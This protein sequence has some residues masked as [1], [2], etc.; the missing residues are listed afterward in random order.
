MD[1]RRLFAKYRESKLASPI[2]SSPPLLDVELVERQR[3]GPDAAPVLRGL[4]LAPGPRNRTATQ[5]G[6]VEVL[7]GREG[8]FLTAR[9]Q[10]GLTTLLAKRDDGSPAR[11][12]V[13]IK[14]AHPG[15]E[16]SDVVAMLLFADRTLADFGRIPI[17][18]AASAPEL[19]E[20]LCAS[21]LAAAQS[22]YRRGASKTY[23]HQSVV[24]RTVKG[25]LDMKD[26]ALRRLRGDPRVRSARHLHTAE[27][28]YNWVVA[29]GL[30][31]ASL[32]ASDPSLRM[33]CRAA[34]RLYSERRPPFPRLDRRLKFVGQYAHYRHL[35]ALAALLAAG[36][37]SDPAAPGA[38]SFLP[39]SITPHVLF[40]RF[41]ARYLEQELAGLCTVRRGIRRHVFE[42]QDG[43]LL[44]TRGFLVPDIEI[45]GE[46]GHLRLLVDAK[47][48]EDFPA[49]ASSDFYQ[50]YVYS[51]LLARQ[52]E[53]SHLPVVLVAPYREVQIAGVRRPS[54]TL[55][56]RPNRPAVWLLG[57]PLAEMS[58]EVLTGEPGP[59]A[60]A[61]RAAFEELLAPN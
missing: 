12:R 19:I 21:Y 23:V 5:E 45:R 57:I 16:L 48:E 61:I 3:V 33:G 18:S 8:L 53:V 13:C 56:S 49:L 44:R 30:Y 40:E 36:A 41:L 50:A 43:R 52:E 10:V 55:D 60:T 14:P 9:N 24:D 6:L 34:A 38:S 29:E 25:R 28:P 7:E 58:R 46:D 59:A 35:H 20:M 31:R 1:S 27:N 42:D 39:F 51:D 32:L 54:R 37:G 2:V 47:Y 26:F 22:A 17:P 11:L 15:V 4:R